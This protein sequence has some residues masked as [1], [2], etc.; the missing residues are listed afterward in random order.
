MEFG[1]NVAGKR[2]ACKQHRTCLTLG[3]KDAESDFAALCRAH[4]TLQLLMLNLTRDAAPGHVRE[5]A[6]RPVIRAAT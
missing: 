5:Q 4:L 3:K 2:L 1:R 6:L